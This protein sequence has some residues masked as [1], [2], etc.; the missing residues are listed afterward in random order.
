MMTAWKGEADCPKCGGEGT[1]LV[2]GETSTVEIDGCWVCGY[3]HEKDD[4]E[5]FFVPLKKLRVT[6]ERKPPRRS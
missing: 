1:L 5:L 2:S 3:G 6:E 4:H